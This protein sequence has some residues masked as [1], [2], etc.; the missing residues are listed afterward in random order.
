VVS[1]LDRGRLVFVDEMGTHTSLAPLYGYSPRGKRAFFKLPRNR[2]KNT[3]LLASIGCEGMGPSMVVEGST[4][5]SGEVFEAYVEHLLAPTLRAGQV[6]V[7]D[8]LSAHKGGRVRELIEERSCEL[9]Y[10]PPYSPDFN[11]IEQAFSKLKASL[12]RAEARTREALIEA[13]G[14]ALST[15]SAQDASGFFGHC[16]Y[17]SA[18]QLL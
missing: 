6:V 14:A 1:K 5:T 11:P 4:S 8:N 12:R 17:R 13:M 18:A 10:L 15:I 3:T 9:I 7:M 2:G 16:G